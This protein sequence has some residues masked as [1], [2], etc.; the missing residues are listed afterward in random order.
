MTLQHHHHEPNYFAR[1]ARADRDEWLKEAFRI[2]KEVFVKEQFVDEALEYDEFEKQSHHYVA[3]YNDEVLGT[4]RWRETPE[5]VK[6]ERFAILK[7]YRGKG[8]GSALLQAALNDIPAGKKIYLH[9]QTTAA[10][11][12]EGHG[13][14]KVG[15]EFSEAGIKHYKMVLNN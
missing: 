4:C 7:P 8:L 9:A 6:L 5:G 1:I 2:R 3:I 14:S 10:P 11:F 13:F 12:Y 15:D